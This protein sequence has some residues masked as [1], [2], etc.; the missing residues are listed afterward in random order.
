MRS[1]V[2]RSGEP[3]GVEPFRPS[4]VSR[5]IRIDAF[6]GPDVVTVVTGPAPVPSAGQVLVRVL[7][8]TANSTDVVVRKGLYPLLKDK[9]PL[10]LG[11]D[12][13]GVVE[14]HGTAP[15]GHAP[16]PPIGSTVAALVQVGG[17]ADHIVLSPDL[18]LPVPPTLDPT[19]VA[20][21][22]LSYLT[23]HQML[24]HAASLIEG[25]TILVHGG[26]GAVGTALLQLARHRGL[27][28][29]ATA[30]TGKLDHIRTQGG[31]AL[32]RSSPDLDRQLAA[33][34]GLAGGGFAAVFDPRGIGVGHA[35]RLLRAGGTLVGYS[36]L[37]QA[38][39]IPRRTPVA[40]ARFGAGYA[41][42]RLGLA[43]RDRLPGGRSARFFGIV[44]SARDHP[45]RLAADFS[46]LCVLLADGVIDPVVTVLPLDRARG[47]HELLDEHSTPGQLVLT[48]GRTT[49][50]DSAVVTQPP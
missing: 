28:T 31:T 30:S 19:R 50:T 20:P 35:M 17:N 42:L 39:A 22:T 40:F 15:D 24:T 45:R 27:R 13:V 9:P 8:S 43:V 1:G 38:D 26:S 7:A 16:F 37:V 18:L 46:H 6:G 47:A 14:A 32:D 10:T 2:V 48:T 12:L 34:A 36:T 21:L 3:R 25:D 11:Y 29:V 5:R 41:R 4:G 44:D 33:Q 49:S 23:A